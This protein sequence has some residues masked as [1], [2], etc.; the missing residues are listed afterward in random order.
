MTAHKKSVCT[1]CLPVLSF[2][3][4]CRYSRKWTPT[5]H[6]AGVL[7]EHVESDAL[8]VIVKFNSFL[9]PHV[10]LLD[11]DFEKHFEKVLTSFRMMPHYLVEDEIIGEGCLFPFFFLREGLEHL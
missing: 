3:P 4:R 1:P 7:Y 2:R 9:A 11:F 10:H 5:V 8:R 6:S